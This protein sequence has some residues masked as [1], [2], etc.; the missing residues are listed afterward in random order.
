MLRAMTV[1]SF[2]SH[3]PPTCQVPNPVLGFVPHPD[4]D[5]CNSTLRCNRMR[6]EKIE[7][8]HQR[9]IYSA[10]RSDLVWASRRGSVAVLG[11]SLSLLMATGMARLVNLAQ[12]CEVDSRT[13]PTWGRLACRRLD[14][15]IGFRETPEARW[16]NRPG[17]R[18]RQCPHHH[19]EVCRRS[20]MVAP[21]RA[22]V[23]ARTCCQKPTA[24]F[25]SCTRVEQ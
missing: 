12:R 17:H 13:S 2:A 21:C 19:S 20:P 6:G 11:C 5:A 4:H 9:T 3:H 8:E 18:S 10:D 16:C 7:R 15:S 23:H 24:S 25:S 1:G 14:N 22:R